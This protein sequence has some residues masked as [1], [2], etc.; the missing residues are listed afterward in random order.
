MLDSL[1]KSLKISDIPDDNIPLCYST[2]DCMGRPKSQ[3]AGWEQA[4]DVIQQEDVLQEETLKDDLNEELT[5]LHVLL[6]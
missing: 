4:G 6:H 5:D 3:Q 2:G 1:L